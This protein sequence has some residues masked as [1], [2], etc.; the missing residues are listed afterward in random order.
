MKNK[1]LAT[2]L[3][4]GIAC[5]GCSA[6]TQVR[7]DGEGGKKALTAAQAYEASFKAFEDCGLDPRGNKGDLVIESHWDW[8]GIGPAS[9]FLLFPL[10]WAKFRAEVRGD[11]VELEGDAYG[12]NWLGIWMNFPVGFPLGRVKERIQARLDE[13]R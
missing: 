7:Y 2:A 1:L 9:Q 8:L 6:R 12:A 11:R 4:A 5:V 10:S 13:L 3:L